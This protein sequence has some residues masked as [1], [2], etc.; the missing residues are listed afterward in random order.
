LFMMGLEWWR[1]RRLV[2]AVAPSAV[3]VPSVEG[4]HPVAATPES[5]AAPVTNSVPVEAK[6]LTV[7]P[8]APAKAPRRRAQNREGTKEGA[9]GTVGARAHDRVAQEVVAPTPAPVAEPVVVPARAVV[10][11]VTPAPPARRRGS[12]FDPVEESPAPAP[13]SPE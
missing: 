9:A 11:P 6:P 2:G 7:A 8:T 5:G 12:H 1:G 4:A 3:A 13:P 10:Q